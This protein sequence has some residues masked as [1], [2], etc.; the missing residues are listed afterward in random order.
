MFEFEVKNENPQGSL[1]AE[2]AQHFQKNEF[3]VTHRS[4]L[5]WG[6]HCTECAIPQ[7]YS[8]CD[9]YSARS[10]GKCRRFLYGLK[11]YEVKNSFLWLCP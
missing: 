2:I 6:E 11:R 4:V 1:S 10:D 5:E 9:F 7:C 8:T 3:I